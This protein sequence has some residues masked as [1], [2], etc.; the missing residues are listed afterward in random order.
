MLEALNLC[1]ERNDRPLFSGLSFAVQ[2][3]DLVQVTGE[4]GAGKTTLLRLLAGLA[5]PESGEVRWEG[6]P[7]AAVRE[8]FHSQLLWLGHQPGIKARLTARENLG[9]YHPACP[10][11][12]L[13]LTGLKGYEDSPVGQLSAGQQRRVALARLW[14][15]PARVWILDEPFTAI[16]AAGV[17]LLTQRLAQHAR[18][19]GAAIFTSHQPLSGLTLPLRRISLRDDAPCC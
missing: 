10:D 1:C 13:R 11:A 5:A 4:N 18:Q 15:S 3:G 12:A 6:K 16:D 2:P 14:L 9:F 19:G 8:S 17:A 7:L